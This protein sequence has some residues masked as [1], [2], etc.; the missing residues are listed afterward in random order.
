M[1]LLAAT[2]SAVTPHTISHGRFND[3][4]IYRPDGAVKGFALLM[5]SSRGWDGTAQ[6]MAQTLAAQGT[7]VAGIDSAK[8]FAGIEAEPGKCTFPDG[9]MEN[10]SRFIQAYEKLPTYFPPIM[11][12]QQA[13]ATMAYALSAQAAP[14]RF[15]GLLSVDFQPELV[16]RKPLCLGEGTHFTRAANG[17]S[18]TLLPAPQLSHPWIALQSAHPLTDA[19]AKAC[20]P[21]DVRRFVARVKGTEVQCVAA[22][23]DKD[24][25]KA[26]WIPPFVAAF[27]KLSAERPPVPPP[28]P[29]S[30]ADLPVI[31]V[32]AR[33]AS[34]DTLA[35]LLSG[36]GG[37]AG[38]DRDVAGSLSKAGVPVVGVDS[39]RYFWTR[40]T[41]EST[42]HDM[43]RLIRFYMAR[44]NKTRVLLIGYSQG[45][46]VLPFVANRLPA[47]T[48]L[49]VPLVVMMGLGQ[50]AA[51]EFQVANWLTAPVSGLP[52]LPET[53]RMPAGLGMCLY[54]ADEKDSSCPQ[55][56]GTRTQLVKLPGG[57]HFDGD[58]DKL[59]RLILDTARAR[60]S[61]R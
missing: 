44:W 13:G 38:L 15:G 58:Y 24:D 49:H 6:L 19:G 12:G 20:G 1:A 16:L 7:M 45:A 46:D 11:V 2:A 47:A 22:P 57:H 33:G 37:W 31:E 34:N 10:L 40:R 3:V 50:K 25:A 14:T 42:T 56:D 27:A 21:A 61:P 30:I 32:A 26:A 43:D 4:P 23:T 18:M 59:A 53:Q 17:Q 60:S 41:P 55:L 54:G 5:S 48:A 8:L 36:D 51:F 39:L 29:A 35:I 52:I 9:D 28:P